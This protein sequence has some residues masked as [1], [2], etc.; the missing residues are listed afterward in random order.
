[1]NARVSFVLVLAVAACGSPG[2]SDDDDDGPVDGPPSDKRG[3]QIV[4]PEIEIAPGAEITYCYYFRTPNTEPMA[5]NRWKSQMTAGSHHMI[6]FLTGDTDKMP[7]G[8]VSE[9]ACGFSSFPPPEWTFAAQTLEAD[10]TLPADDGAGQPLAQEV[11]DGTAGFIQM[12]YFNGADDPIKA[13]VVIDAEALDMGVP[14]TKTAPFITY[15]SNIDIAPYAKDHVETSSCSVPATAKFWMMSTH[16]HKRADNTYV[17]DGDAMLFHGE[18]WEHPGV[19]T[20]NAP[21]FRTFASGKLTY[22]CEYDNPTGRM[23]EDGDRAE[24][25]EMCMATGYFFPATK[26]LFCLNNNGPF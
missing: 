13:H 2:T 10:L 12:H 5:I 7:P 24:Y 23:F 11:P 20:W 18:D 16:A 21:E 14:Y 8:T 9:D 3:F 25:D 4:S 26:P 22:E 15:N 17:K 6:L 1:M 19:T